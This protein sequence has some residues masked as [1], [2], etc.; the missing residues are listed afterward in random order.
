[1]NQESMTFLLDK[2]KKKRILA[3]ASTTNTDLNDILNEALTA[4]LEV[5]DWQVEEIK[6][7]LVEAD[8]GDFA[9]EEEVEAV[10]ERLTR[11]N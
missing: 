6:Q 11:G 3:I 10:F 9:S 2:D 7:A 1:M 4:Y 8:A 5:N